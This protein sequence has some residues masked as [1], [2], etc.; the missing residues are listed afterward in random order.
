V[1]AELTWLSSVG[2]LQSFQ[3]FELNDPR[4]WS[5]LIS[6]SVGFPEFIVAI[7]KSVVR[8]FKT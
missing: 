6:H 3:E 4:I 7:V 8:M 1:E 2:F 5:P